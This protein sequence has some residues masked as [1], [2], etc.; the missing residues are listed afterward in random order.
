MESYFT[1]ENILKILIHNGKIDVIE[2]RQFANTYIKLMS[3]FL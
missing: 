3:Y 2:L 1:I